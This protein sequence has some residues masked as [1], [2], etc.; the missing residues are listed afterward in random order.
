MKKIL[1]AL[2]VS[3]SAFLFVACSSQPVSQTEGVYNMQVLK[4]YQ[5]RVATGDTVSAQQKA[6]AAQYLE[7]EMKLNASDERPK[8]SERTISPPVILPSIGLGY[9]GHYW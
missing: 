4:D 7:P 5:T 8:V 2:Y 1:T 3:A 9:Y 6:R